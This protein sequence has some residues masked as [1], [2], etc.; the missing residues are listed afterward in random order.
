MLIPTCLAHLVV[1]AHLA[2]W[3]CYDIA[4]KLEPVQC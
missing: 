4:E 2:T 3:Q 1:L